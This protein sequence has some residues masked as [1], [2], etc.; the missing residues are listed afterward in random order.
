M[1]SA[2]GQRSA[3]D[4]TLPTFV[5][6]Q[7]RGARRLHKGRRPLPFHS[8]PIFFGRRGKVLLSEALFPCPVLLLPTPPKGF[9]ETAACGLGA[10]GF[11]GSSLSLRDQAV[12][13][14]VVI[15]NPDLGQEM[16]MVEDT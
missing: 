8:S 11:W 16:G 1:G 14:D 10:A 7:Q 9:S 12:V 3:R 13:P 15:G 2:H 6:W 4:R 5:G